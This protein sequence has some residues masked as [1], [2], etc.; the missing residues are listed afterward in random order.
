MTGTPHKDKSG[1]QHSQ[2]WTDISW[3]R[4]ATQ[5]TNQAPHRCA[6]AVF[7]RGERFPRSP[8]ME[9]WK[10]G[11]STKKHLVCR[12]M[13]WRKEGRRTDFKGIKMEINGWGWE[14]IRGGKEEGSKMLARR[15]KIR[16]GRGRL[17][18][19]SVAYRQNNSTDFSAGQAADEWWLN[20]T[21]VWEEELGGWR[22]RRSA[23]KAGRRT[24]RGDQ[25]WSWQAVEKWGHGKMRKRR[26]LLGGSGRSWWP[27]AHSMVFSQN[28]GGFWAACKEMNEA[29]DDCWLNVAFLTL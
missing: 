13:S 27:P 20:I 15:R 3:S 22:R 10:R 19:H 5:C 17:I 9:T 8:F 24:E 29:G 25:S 23:R 21:A 26:R 1:T 14:S 2:C 16:S 7:L 28:N 11:L 4:E 18:A 6:A 12:K